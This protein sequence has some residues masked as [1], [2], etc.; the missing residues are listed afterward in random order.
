M[1]HHAAHLSTVD[2]NIKENCYFRKKMS[3]CNQR[4]SFTH[5]RLLLFASGVTVLHPFCRRVLAVVGRLQPHVLPTG[6]TRP[7]AW[8]VFTFW[9]CYKLS[10]KTNFAWLGRSPHLAQMLFGSI[11][12]HRLALSISLS[13]SVRGFP[14]QM[15]TL[16]KRALCVGEHFLGGN[17]LLCLNN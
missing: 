11:V 15:W 4:L 16:A 7:W 14:S 12:F 10:A 17:P 3:K 13:P 8:N 1:F 5:C 6:N 9:V 2:P